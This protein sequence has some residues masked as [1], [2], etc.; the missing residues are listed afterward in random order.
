MTFYWAA[1][2]RLPLA[3]VDVDP[4]SPEFMLIKANSQIESLEHQLSKRR[5]LS[6][7]RAAASPKPC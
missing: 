4:L 2:R 5:S 7:S 1:N 6:R 3:A